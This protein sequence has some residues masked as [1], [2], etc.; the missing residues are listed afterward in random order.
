MVNEMEPA[1]P[2]SR[3]AY[4]L[5][6]KREQNKYHLTTSVTTILL[7]LISNCSAGMIIIPF[8]S[9]TLRFINTNGLVNLSLIILSFLFAPVIACCGDKAAT[10]D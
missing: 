7:L 3:L 6:S 4:N 8:T 5:A 9:D 10:E 2:V 1:S